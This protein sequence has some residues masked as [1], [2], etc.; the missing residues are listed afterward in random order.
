MAGG[1]NCCLGQASSAGDNA[2][3]MQ[4]ELALLEEY[5]SASTDQ[6]ATGKGSAE[7]PHMELQLDGFD[8]RP[9]P[10]TPTRKARPP[11]ALKKICI[12][13]CCMHGEYYHT[14][15]AAVPSCVCLVGVSLLLTKIFPSRALLT[16]C[17]G[18][19]QGLTAILTDS[20]LRQAVADCTVQVE[21]ESD[22]DYCPEEDT[23]SGTVRR[24]RSYNVST[25]TRKASPVPSL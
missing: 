6:G 9:S 8:M 3:P 22:R 4:Q 5:P 1:R 15:I 7:E 24:T 21:S 10:E 17:K 13:V 14:Y 2:E 11:A 25:G 23:D 19:A 20:A 12:D 18:S 16:S